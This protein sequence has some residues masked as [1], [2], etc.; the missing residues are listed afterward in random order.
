[1][2]AKNPEVRN[3]LEVDDVAEF[4]KLFRVTDFHEEVL[5]LLDRTLATVGFG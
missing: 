4:A 2:F 1:M 5:R 3:D